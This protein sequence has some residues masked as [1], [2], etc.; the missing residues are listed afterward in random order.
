MTKVNCVRYMKTAGSKHLQAQVIYI[1]Y[2]MK[3]AISC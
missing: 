1:A 2:F 3:G